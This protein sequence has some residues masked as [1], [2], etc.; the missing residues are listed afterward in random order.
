MNEIKIFENEQFG[1]IRTVISETN[2][3]M[4]CLADVCKV[5]DIKNVSDCRTRLS[6]KGIVITDTPTK[7][8]IQSMVFVNETNLY[9]CIFQSRKPD[10]EQ[11]QEWVCEE[12][13]PS[14][15][16]NGG[17]IANQENLTPEQIVANALVVAQNIINNQNKAIEEMKPKAIFADSVSASSTS[18]LIGDLAKIIHQNGC[19]MGQKRLFKWLR[20]NKY[21]ISRAGSDYNS[22]TQTS[23]DKG[24]F[25]IKETAI[26]HSDGHI[27]VNKTVK[28]TGAGQIYF[29][30]KF[31]K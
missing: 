14:I 26:T 4:F 28:V 11:F 5:L 16:K 17:Y 7:G 18:I 3:P 25:F 13:L 15:R 22:P 20:D 27:T 12:V 2:E 6:Q 30:N 10:A 1:K 9:K 29:I 24:L 21:L 31:K 23:M 8:G 19:E